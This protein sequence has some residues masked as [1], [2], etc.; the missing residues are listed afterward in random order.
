MKK[1][2]FIITIVLLFVVI[3]FIGVKIGENKVIYNQKVYTD[4]PVI[5]EYNGQSNIYN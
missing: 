4:Y 3:F 1:I 2:L 5:I